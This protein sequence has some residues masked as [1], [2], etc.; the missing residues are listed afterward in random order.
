MTGNESNGDSSNSS[1]KRNLTR[2]GTPADLP[3]LTSKR[4]KIK[5]S[6]EKT[7]IRIPEKEQK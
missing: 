7:N 2:K 6:L 4:K 5:E 1:K 3:D